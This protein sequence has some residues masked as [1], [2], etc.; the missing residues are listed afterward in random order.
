M[1]EAQTFFEQVPIETV[2]KICEGR[3][4]RRKQRGCADDGIV[5]NALDKPELGNSDDAGHSGEPVSYE[6][7][8]TVADEFSDDLKYPQWQKPLQAALLEFDPQQLQERIAAAEAAISARLDLLSKGPDSVAER[9]AIQ[10]GL[11]LL[12]FLKERSSRIA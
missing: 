4:S 1:S 6:R 11:R 9:L 2:K 12:S 10:D 8:V 3:I 7:S 5:Q